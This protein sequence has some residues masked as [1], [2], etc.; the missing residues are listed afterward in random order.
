LIE[1]Q[2]IELTEDHVGCYVKQLVSGAAYIH[3]LNVILRVSE[4]R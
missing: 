3:S 4:I 1:S 2:G